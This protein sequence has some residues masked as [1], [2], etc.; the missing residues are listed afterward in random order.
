MVLWATSAAAPPLLGKLGLPTDDRGFLLTRPTLV[1]TGD[2]S[3]FAVGD[4]GT[5]EG[6]TLPKAGVY[7][8]RQGPILWENV[9]RVL[10][11]RPP[12]AYHLCGFEAHQHRR[13]PRHW[14]VQRNLILRR[15]GVEAEGPHRPQVHGDVPGLYAHARG[16][17][18]WP[19]R[20]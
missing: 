1:S 4:S 15:L 13:W 17:G 7:A 9:Q 16:A 2:H 11:G 19:A 18:L 8:V 5:I 14:G 3:I 6:E 10:R 20:A 12:A